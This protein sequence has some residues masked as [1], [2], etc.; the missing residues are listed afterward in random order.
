MNYTKPEVSTLGY[1][2]KVIELVNPAKPY[3]PGTDGTPMHP[4]ASPAYDLDE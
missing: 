1:A 2:T 4:K 3:Q